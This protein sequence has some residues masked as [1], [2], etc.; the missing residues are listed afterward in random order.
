MKRKLWLP[1]I[2]LTSLSFVGCKGSSSGD[3]S[4]STIDGSESSDSSAS[5]N[6]GSGV[7]TTAFDGEET[8]AE[9]SLTTS[10]GN[11]TNSGTTYTI[12]AAGTYTASGKLS[13]GQIYIAAGE[14]D[15]IELNLEGVSISNSSNSPIFIASASKVE[16]SA[17]SDTYNVITDSRS[18][19]TADSE[20]QGEG[21][22]YAKS[23]LKLKGS[24]ILK[25]TGTYNNG[26]HTSKDLTIQ[27]ESLYVEAYNNGI[28]GNHKVNITSG[29]ILVYATNGDGIKSEDTDLSNSGNQRGSINISGGEIEIYSQYDGVDAAYDVNIYNGVDESDNTTTTKPTVTVYTNTYMQY[30]KNYSYVKSKARTTFNAPGGQGGSGGGFPGEGTSTGPGSGQGFGGSTSEKATDSA[31]ALKGANKVYIKGGSNYLFAY[32]DCVHANSG[33]TFTSGAT[34]VGNVEISGGNTTIFASDDGI[35]ADNNVILSGGE[36]TIGC[37]YE[38]I[39][40]KSGITISGGTHYAY[41]SDDGL[42][43]SSSINVTGGF[44]FVGVPT[45]GDVDTIDSNG[46]YTQ[47]GGVVIAIG[48]NSGMASCLDVDGSASVTGGSFICFGGLEKTPSAS[49]V[50]TSSKSGSYSFS[51]STTQKITYSNNTTITGLYLTISSSTTSGL[52]TPGSLSSSVCNSY[53]SNGSIS[54]IASA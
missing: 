15:E 5:T 54:S 40:A 13:E 21:A 25:V 35:H 50:T 28:K 23:D 53:S 51:S 44:M 10:D 48:P 30:G 31:K 22:I 2:A 36:T 47:S 4:A 45:S 12:S 46:T 1:I 37:A 32:D 11:V 9:F 39:E 33:T 14:D 17:K 24:G 41:A 52:N 19:K 16:I 38:G 26:V 6:D 3:D 49:K 18:A 20:T 29:T 8:T 27:K 42:N 43:A 34:A 7:S